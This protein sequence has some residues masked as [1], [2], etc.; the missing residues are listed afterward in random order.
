MTSMVLCHQLSFLKKLRIKRVASSP[1]REALGK[2]LLDV[3]DRSAL[4]QRMGVSSQREVEASV[5][6]S[7]AESG[8]A[9]VSGLTASS[10]WLLTRLQSLAELKE[11]CRTSLSVIIASLLPRGLDKGPD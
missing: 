3:S 11:G 10:L 2:N 4:V 9:P 6:C 8:S 5:E 1:Q 7:T